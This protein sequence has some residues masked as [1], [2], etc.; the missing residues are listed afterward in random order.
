MKKS[1]RSDPNRK[2]ILFIIGAVALY[3]ILTLQLGGFGFYDIPLTLYGII[4]SNPD[5]ISSNVIAIIVDIVFF[6]FG[7]LIFW[8]AFF[9]QFVLP[10]NSLKDRKEVMNR[11]LATLGAGQGPAIFVQDGEIIDDPRYGDRK[12]EG[13]IILDTSSA[14]V[15]HDQSS[16]TR[17]VGPG[18]VFTLKKEGITGTIDLHTQVRSLG[19]KGDDE[20]PF[21]SKGEG[22]SEE[23]FDSRIERRLQ[24]S[25]LTR[26]GVELVP[27][28]TAVFRL[29]SDA[30][31]GD[32]QYGYNHDAAWRAM[33]FEGIDPQAPSDAGSR[34]I[35]WDW[36]PTHVASDV[37][38][39]YLGKFTLNNLFEY[40][41]FAQSNENEERNTVFE[42]IVKKVNDRM[43]QGLVDEIDDVGLPTGR[44][45]SSREFRI[46]RERGIKIINISINNLHFESSVEKKFVDQW[47]ATWLQRAVDEQRYIEGRQSIEKFKGQTAAQ[48]EFSTMVS[49]AL[50]TRISS[51]N[52]QSQD[53][54]TLNQSV[55]L[56]VRSTLNGIIRNPDLHIQLEEEEAD[57]VELI[58]WLRKYS[59]D[60]TRG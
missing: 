29:D 47:T 38:R 59:S 3:I 20:D 43:K 53:T 30:G 58:E 13:V 51:N 56:L 26:D 39:E 15:L 16:F 21:N 4:D 11:L 54:P 48:Q 5:W 60:P 44:K 12:G 31:E 52:G 35:S 37:W 6:V 10:V 2:A 33:A 23:D 9:S 1:R 22:E 49:R 17:A 46:M 14:A 27:N 32:T 19:P 36:L 50:Y 42:Y 45:I 18:L 28:I 25:A 34:H 8:L 40:S 41:D 57:L 55:E 24:T 7:G